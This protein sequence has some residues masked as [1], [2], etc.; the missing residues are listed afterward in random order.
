[1][2][3]R[4]AKSANVR[5][6]P[7]LD[8]SLTGMVYAGIMFFMGLGAVNSQVNLLFAIFGLMIG[9]L[10]VSWVLSRAALR[11]L[12]IRRIL[13][14]HM[15][16]GSPTAVQ[17]E[18]RNLKRFWPSCSITIGELS[19]SDAFSRQPQGYLLHVPP[20][21]MATV[22]M[23]VVPIRRGVYQLDRY[24]LS[25]SF[26]FGFIKRAINGRQKDAVVVYP[27]PGEV[28]QRLLTMFLSAERVGSRMRP[29]RGGNDE[30]YGVKEFRQGENPRWIYWRRS[31]HTGT[32]VAKEMTQVAPPRILVLVDTFVKD[33]SLQVRADV[34]RV[35]AMAASLVSTAIDQGLAIG[36]CAWRDGW[37]CINPGRGKRHGRDLLSLLAQLPLNMTSDRGSLIEHA[38]RL[39][40]VGTTP[41]LFT[42][43]NVE[44]TLPDQARG[45]W[46]VIPANS[47]QGRQ[48]FRFDPGV[49]FAQCIPADAEPGDAKPAT[50]G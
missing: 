3:L 24:Q 13:P 46:I 38:A 9:V 34:E 21:S 49:D 26:P 41:V 32:L 8:L 15:V 1:M 50:G 6:K 12:S 48:W 39:I 42:P 43:A 20:S 28:D 37:V 18:V 2:A 14:E 45:N 10:V 31:A 17:Y 36:L 40:R 11:K 35:I 25:T 33:L 47:E 7:S 22:P 19:G 23:Q 30:F 5:R 16:V 4:R 44:Q 29:R 27:P